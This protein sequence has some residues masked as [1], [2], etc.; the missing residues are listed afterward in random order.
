MYIFIY[1][2]SILGNPRNLPYYFSSGSV[3]LGAAWRQLQNAVKIKIS[4]DLYMYSPVDYDCR[5][6][7]C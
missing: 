1:T 4:P 7:F 5:A 6:Q 2:H 3:E